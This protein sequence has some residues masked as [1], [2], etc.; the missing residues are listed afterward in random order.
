MRKEKGGRETL[1][2]GTGVADEKRRERE[3]DRWERR[4][5]RERSRWNSAS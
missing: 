1:I 5:G 3:K 2:P 4:R